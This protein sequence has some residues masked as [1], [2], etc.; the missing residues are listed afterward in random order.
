MATKVDVST[1]E[2]F[3]N[4]KLKAHLK[5]TGES[6]IKSDYEAMIATATTASREQTIASLV[7]RLGD[8]DT[9]RGIKIN[10]SVLEQGARLLA[11]VYVEDDVTLLR[12]DALKLAEEA[13]GLGDH[14]VRGRRRNGRVHE[15]RASRFQSARY[16][17]S[18]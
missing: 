5:L 1:I 13:S 8:G 6:G 3:L 18:Q 16:R 2:S 4:C 15:P 17:Y 11:D 7:A 10:R 9:G 12:F 14:R